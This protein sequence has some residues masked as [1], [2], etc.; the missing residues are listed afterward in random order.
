MRKLLFI[1]S[2]A[3]VVLFT[4]CKHSDVKP[5]TNKKP[6][7][8]IEA[9][10][11]EPTEEEIEQEKKREEELE[12]A[13]YRAADTT[14]IAPNSPY[15]Y[16]PAIS[17][18]QFSE[19]GDTMKYFPRKRKGGH[20]VVPEGVAYLQERVFQCC[21]RVR[22]IIFPKSLKH[23]EMAVCDYCPQLRKVVFKSPIREVPFCGFTFC[24]RLRELHLVDRRPPVS[25]YEKDENVDEEE[26]FYTFGGVNAKKCVIFVP[27]GCAKRY[28][29]HRLWRKFKHIVEE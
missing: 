5:Q 4:R 1:I 18:P 20:Y 3:L 10:A 25:P 27:K 15:W 28:K 9:E 2:I 19:D 17:E 11:S 21:V 6:V 16:D 7:A 12:R 8:A 14:G 26:W 22:S 13:A 23:I 24:R 29:R